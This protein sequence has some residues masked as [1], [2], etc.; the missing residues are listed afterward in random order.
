MG[1]GGVI[2]KK[3]SFKICL[4][5]SGGI[6]AHN[7]P[8]TYIRSNSYI[9]PWGVGVLHIGVGRSQ[10]PMCKTTPQGGI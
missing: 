9:P 4:V 7:E 1:S 3:N 5:K 6:L 10:T 2:P 8:R